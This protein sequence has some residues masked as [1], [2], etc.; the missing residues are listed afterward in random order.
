MIRSRITITTPKLLRTIT[1]LVRTSSVT[2][3]TAF[4]IPGIALAVFPIAE[5]FRVSITG[6]TMF[7]T[8][9]RPTTVPRSVFNPQLTATSKS[10]AILLS[11]SSFDR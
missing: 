5:R 3:V 6:L 9:C 4:P 2:A 7:L 11:I 10:S 1:A 8:I